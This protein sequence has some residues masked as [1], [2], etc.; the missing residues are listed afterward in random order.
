[1]AI[2]DPI[3][4]T[5]ARLRDLPNGQ[6]EAAEIP[7]GEENWYRL[8]ESYKHAGDRL[9]GLT[10][11]SFSFAMLGAPTLFLYRH[12]IELHLKSLL[13]DAGELLDN[14]QAILPKHY[15]LSLWDRVRKL[16]I[17]ISPES[18]G[19][20]FDRANQ[21][22]ADFDALDSSSFAFRYPVDTSGKPPLPSP[23]YIDT[24]VARRVVAE[25]HILL[26]GASSQIAEYT[27]LKHEGC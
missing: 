25:L 27:S 24:R 8:A 23:L 7:T 16:L 6:Y 14:P 19:E 10:K 26:S 20:W 1:M 3:I 12:Y 21:V 4:P 11:D 5:D 13:I 18:A 2:F 22:I 17:T 15:L 9:A